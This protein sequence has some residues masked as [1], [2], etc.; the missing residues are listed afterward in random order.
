M[1]SSRNSSEVSLP[2]LQHLVEEVDARG[3]ILDRVLA[4]RI[5]HEVERDPRLHELVDERLAVL[6][7]D[8]VVVGP[9]DEHQPAVQVLRM[10]NV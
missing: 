8:V 5:D 6:R 7:M 2:E 9:E 1:S 10:R 3:A 4:H